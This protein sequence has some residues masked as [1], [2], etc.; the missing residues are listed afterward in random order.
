MV[1]DEVQKNAHSHR[2]FSFG[3]GQGASTQLIK[4]IAKATSG[5]AEFITGKERM[6]PKVLQ[7]LKFALQPAVSDLTIGW[8]LPSGVEAALL[9]QLPTVIFNGQ[10]SIVYAQLK[11]EVDPSLEA[12][13]SLKYSLG[14][15]LFQNSIRFKLQ[16]QDSVRC[17]VHRLAAKRMIA[18]FESGPGRDSPAAKQRVVEISSQANVVSSQT[19]FVATNKELGQP[20]RGPMVRRNVPL[21]WGLPVR[22]CAPRVM[23]RSCAGPMMGL[24]VLGCAPTLQS[25]TTLFQAPGPMMGGGVRSRRSVPNVAPSS[26]VECDS[27]AVCQ[28][29]SP[30]MKLIAVQN[31]D[32][33]WSPDN[34]LEA[35]LGLKPQQSSKSLPHKG[36]DLTVWTTILAVIWLHAFSA[37]T[38]DEWELLVGKSL[39]WIKV[40]AGSDLGECLKAGNALLKCSVDPRVFGL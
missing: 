32:G 26:A 16:P 18:A 14:E 22:G 23:L 40:K 15:E 39:S 20:L 6:Q 7:S 9:S 37:D 17:T 13:M 2:C 33:S 12:E 35:L 24:P 1:I 11:G 28:D 8:E 3:I 38:K 21:P 27:L 4:G 30:A 25:C 10:R 5:N 36:I 34:S 31:A 19:A 29:Q